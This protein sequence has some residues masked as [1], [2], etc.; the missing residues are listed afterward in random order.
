MYTIIQNDLFL[1]KLKNAKI[2]KIA[3]NNYYF[4]IVSYFIHTH[5]FKALKNV[6]VE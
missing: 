6:I 4:L 3:I 5:N 2:Y 1:G